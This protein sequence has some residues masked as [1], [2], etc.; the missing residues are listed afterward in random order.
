[1]LLLQKEEALDNKEKFITELVGKIA[2]LNETVDN[3]MKSDRSIRSGEY[4]QLAN[5]Q[6]TEEVEWCLHQAV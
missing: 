6:Y 4:Q 1:M 5:F 2:D 3:I